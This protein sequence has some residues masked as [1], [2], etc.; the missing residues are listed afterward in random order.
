MPKKPKQEKHKREGKRAREENL[1]NSLMEKKEGTSD[2]LHPPVPPQPKKEAEVT[3]C[4]SADRTKLE[5]QLHKIREQGNAEFES[6][7]DLLEDRL[8][9]VTLKMLEDIHCPQKVVTRG[10]PAGMSREQLAY[11]LCGTPRSPLYE[12]DKYAERFLR[13]LGNPEVTWSAIIESDEESEDSS[14]DEDSTDESDDSD[15]SE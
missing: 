6:F 7:V 2:P 9:P 4:N 1:I 14:E 13:D 8:M 11:M 5:E 12:N 3:P 15:D 10:Y